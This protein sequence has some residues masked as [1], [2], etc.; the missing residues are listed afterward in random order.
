MDSRQGPRRVLLSADFG[1]GK[2]S[3]RLRIALPAVPPWLK[4]GSP[5]DTVTLLYGAESQSGVDPKSGAGGEQ[6]ISGAG[7]GFVDGVS[8]WTRLAIICAAE[9]ERT[10]RGAGGEAAAGGQESGA[11]ARAAKGGA[12]TVGGAEAAAAVGDRASKRKR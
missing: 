9:A 2:A 7:V 10:E 1:R 12:A 11:G 8:D 3:H 5:S 6:S 4:N